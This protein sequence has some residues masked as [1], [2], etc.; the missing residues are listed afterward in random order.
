[1]KCLY[2]VYH[3]NF[4]IHFQKSTVIQRLYLPLPQT[5]KRL[6]E[7]VLP[8]AARGC[9]TGYVYDKCVNSAV[10][11]N[12]V[13]MHQNTTSS[14]SPKSRRRKPNHYGLHPHIPHPSTPR[15]LP[16]SLTHHLAQS[17]TISLTALATLQPLPVCFSKLTTDHR[18]RNTQNMQHK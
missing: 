13:A 18:R 16:L 1:M 9:S 3:A 10:F 14:S 12:L 5:L 8:S 6:Q 11:H 4:T 2:S 17:P 7:S 15:N